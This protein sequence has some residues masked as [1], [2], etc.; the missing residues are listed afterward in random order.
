[1]FESIHAHVQTYCIIIEVSNEIEGPIHF[2]FISE[3]ACESESIRLLLSYHV[4]PQE[5]EEVKEEEEA[6]CKRHWE[7]T[8][9]TSSL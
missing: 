8:I 7:P 6:L 4:I 9:Q 2:P 1:M 3:I 5:M